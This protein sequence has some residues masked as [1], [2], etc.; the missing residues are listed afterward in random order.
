[1]FE[2]P[3]PSFTSITKFSIH[4]NLRKSA[5]YV[6][7]IL[8][9][10]MKRSVYIE[11]WHF[12]LGWV[13]FWLKELPFDNTRSTRA[14]STSSNLCGKSIKT[15]EYSIYPLYKWCIRYML[16]CYT[17][18]ELPLSYNYYL[19]YSKDT[20]CISLWFDRCTYSMP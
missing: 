18:N 14:Q 13:V 20:N 17:D 11:S 12:R 7:Q 6:L 4:F 2:A 16:L 9:F 8:P 10:I 1:M 19:S 5:T 3:I 15:K